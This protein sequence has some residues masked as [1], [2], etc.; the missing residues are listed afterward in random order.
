MQRGYRNF[1]SEGRSR[2]LG[3]VNSVDSVL[4]FQWTV[5]DEQA[6]GEYT[7]KITYPY[8]GY[9]PAERKFDIRNYRP[10]RLK[11]QIKFLRDGY[12]PGDEVAATLEVTRAE[13]GI[14]AGAKVTVI[15]RVD[16]VEIFRGKTSVDENGNA[17]GRFPL[18][19]DIRRGEGTLAM[20]IEDGGVVETASKTIPILLQTVDLTMYPEGGDLVAGLATRIYFEAFTPARDPADLAGV[21]ED[22]AGKQIATFRSEHEGRGRFAFTPEADRKYV[23][24]I[25]EPSGIQ[26]TYP[27]PEVKAAGGTLQTKQNTFAAGEPIDVHAAVTSDK[28]FSVSLQHRGTEIAKVAIRESKPG[29]Q[30]PV[31]FTLPEWAAGVLTATLWDA[32]GKPLAERLVF[33]Q[34][35]Q[36]VNVEISAD[37][38]QYTPGGRAKLTVKTTDANGKPIS[39]VV[40]VTVTDDSVLEMIDRRDQAPRLPVMVLL[41]DDVRELADA[42]VYLDPENEDAETAVDLLLGTQGWRRFALLDLPK[43]LAEHGDTARRALAMRVIT[44]AERRTVSRFRGDLLGAIA[45]KAAEGIELDGAEFGAAPPVPKAAAPPVDEA[46]LADPVASGVE[47]SDAPVAVNEAAPAPAEEPAP[48]AADNQAARDD[49]A[50]VASLAKK[51]PQ[52]AG[53]DLDALAPA[54]NRAAAASRQPAASKPQQQLAQPAIREALKEAELMRRQ[55]KIVGFADELGD[56]EREERIAN[57]FVT[58]RVYAHELRAD[59]QQG[60]RVDFTET[61][62]WSTGLKTDD[63]GTA[64]F[65]FALNDSVTSFQVQTDAFTA[66][67]AIGAASLPIESVEPFYLEPKLPLEVTSGD[68]IRVPVSMVNATDTRF[69]KGSFHVT[70]TSGDIVKRAVAKFALNPEERTR[71]LVSIQVG[72]QPG[73]AELTLDASAGP[74]ADRV[75]RTMQVRPLG[76]PIETGFGGLV[77]SGDTVTHEITIPKELVR[78]SM[79]TRIIVYPTPLASMNEALARLIRE[80]YGCFEQTSSTTYP[81][82]MA[83]QYFLSHE[84][85][86]PSLIERSASILDKGYQRLLGFECKSG[87][88]EWFGND[89]GHDALTA[90]GLMEFN[91][92]S[93]V[94]QVDEAMLDRTRTWLLSQRDGKGGFERKTHTLHTWLATPEVAFPYNTWAL[95][96]AGVDADL[97]EEVKWARSA[98]DKTDNTYVLALAANIM[99]L[100]GDKEGEEQMLDRLAG[101][102][103][104]DGS[105][106][107]AKTSVVGSG[108]QALQIETTSLAALAWLNN[109]SYTPNVEKAIQ[110]LAENCKAGRF[111]STQSTVLALKAIVAYDQARAKPQADGSLQLTVDGKS[112]GEPVKFTADTQGAIE[113]PVASDALTPGTHKIQLAMA[114]GS[115]MPYSIAVDYHSL[116]PSSSDECKLHLDVAL[117]EEKIDEGAITEAQVTVVNRSNEKIPTPTAIIGIPGGLEVRHDQLKEL[118]KAGTIA[119]YEV[120]GRE[121]VLYWLSMDAEQRIE[122]PISMVAAIPGSYSGP[123][124]RAYLYYTDEHKTWVDGLSCTI[125]PVRTKRN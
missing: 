22:A 102:Q 80:P 88:F 28:G 99:V 109:S 84:G 3:W 37:A 90:Y 17:V 46:P 91:D 6:G 81:L 108:G 55:R 59:H 39:A 62:Y 1:G 16:G 13:G 97:S 44:E 11:S 75:T 100:A 41:E 32:D 65:E 70:T 58:V 86:D 92:M 66:D 15:G 60:D 101:K 25:T 87:G 30:V 2:C 116:K 18:P 20:L 49:V 76:F 8:L 85:V 83:Q 120:I 104:D 47:P 64:T 78:G 68:H 77:G 31:N 26:S 33:R 122:L 67:G 4:G 98:A 52:N 110:Y 36:S 74:Y 125:Q 57:D 43:F 72:T 45:E 23:M 34:P 113:L 42:H 56:F 7:A 29:K 21:I 10:P 118:V 5:P 73:T 51:L 95:L 82:V 40:G 111:G 19:D 115:E 93:E 79:S 71:K 48:P 54:G 123:A 61:L 105:L 106:K 94:R 114:D 117:A 63:S 24:R 14:P 69:D 103:A 96:S 53:K 9:A 50:E 12:G 107:D 38:P 112:I 121:V 89:P 35:A 27:L 124:S 119:A